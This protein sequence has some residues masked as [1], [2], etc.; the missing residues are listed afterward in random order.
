VGGAVSWFGPL[1][2]ALGALAIVVL[3]VALALRLRTQA[4]CP[5]PERGAEKPA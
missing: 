2:P 5:V 3:G 1:Q 4:S